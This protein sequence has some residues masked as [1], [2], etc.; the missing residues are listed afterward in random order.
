MLNIGGHVLA[1][2][3]VAATNFPIPSIRMPT[4]HYISVST[5]NG[6]WST[7]TKAA[8][9]NYTVSWNETLI[10]N[11]RS[12][13]FPPCLMPIFSGKSKAIL[14][15][16]R[17]SYESGPSELVGVF[18]TSFGQVLVSDVQS[19]SCL[20]VD[21]QHISLTLKAQRIKTTQPVDPAAGGTAESVVTDQPVH[22]PAAVRSINITGQPPLSLSPHAS[23]SNL[24]TSPWGR[25][26]V[27][28]GETGSGKSSIINAI[29]RE[30]LAETS[31]D[32]T[33]CTSFYKRHPVTISGQKFDLFDTVGL[34]EGPAGTVPDA[35]AKRQLK[36]L[37][38]QLMSSKSLSD[39][40]GL[41]VYCVSSRTNALPAIV[42]AYNT[43]YSRVCRKKVPIVIVITGLENERDMESWWDKNKGKFK[44]M[45]F[46]GHACVTALQEYPDTPDDFAHRIAESGDTLRNLLVNNCSHWAVDDSWFMRIAG[47]WCASSSWSKN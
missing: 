22:L 7:T 3:V 42:R 30:Q 36:S 45:H 24:E 10:I 9:A 2:E 40:I 17:A 37:L 29:A 34:G 33:G 18:E 11:G 15:E 25:N 35:E 5:T 28:F 43:F 4:G 1:L 47:L 23:S 6:Q 31:N 20:A 44:S 38:R 19:V 8:T 26:I 46:A 32:T 41:L 21:N 16:L 13:T 39:G 12:L 14:L 27:I